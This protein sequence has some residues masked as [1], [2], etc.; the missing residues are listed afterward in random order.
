[1]MAMV[2]FVTLAVLGIL[3]KVVV[4]LILLPLFLLKWVLTGVVMLIV[5]PILLVVG[6]VLFLAAGLALAVPL[7]PLFAIAAIVWLLF[8][9]TR[10]PAIV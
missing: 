7:L 9:S 4:R 1:M 5:G 2:A 6:A 3:L 8:R 10:R